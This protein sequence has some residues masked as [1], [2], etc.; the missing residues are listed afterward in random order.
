[1]KKQSIGILVAVVLLALVA[2]FTVLGTAQIHTSEILYDGTTIRW[3]KV[4][5]AKH[6][7][8]SINGSAPIECEEASYTYPNGGDF[9]VTI[10]VHKAI[11]PDQTEQKNF[12]Y[13]QT[14]E[15][16]QFADGVLYWNP[17]KDAD[18]YTVEINGITVATVTE[19]R[20]AYAGA[21]DAIFR[22][23]P[24]SNNQAYYALWSTPY[25]AYILPTPQNV[26]YDRASHTI[27][28]DA[29]PFASSY[30][31]WVDN[32]P[33]VTNTNSFFYS[34][35]NASFTVQV[36]AN[37]DRTQQRFD[38]LRS[39]AKTYTYLPSVANLRVQD[40]IVVWDHVVGATGYRVTVNNVEQPQTTANFFADLA[41]NTPYTIAVL[42]INAD[43]NGYSDW[44]T[45]TFTVLPTPTL[46]AP[47]LE[48]GKVAVTWSRVENA[49][50][51]TLRVLR[52]GV[53][54]NEVSLGADGGACKFEDAYAQ[55]GTY[56]LYLCASQNG[57]ASASGWS[58]A[59]TVIRLAAPQNVQIASDGNVTFAPS[60]NAT[61]YTVKV[62]GATAHTALM[63]PT[64]SLSDGNVTQNGDLNLEIWANGAQATAQSILLPSSNAAT[65]IAHKAGNVSG[66]TVSADGVT[67][68][69]TAGA[70]RYWVFISRN[71]GEPQ[72]YEVTENALPCTWDAVGTYRV[73]VYALMDGENTVPSNAAQTRDVVRL[74]APSVRREGD[75]LLWDHVEGA[76]GY[77][78]LI[79]GAPKTSVAQTYVSLAPYATAQ[80]KRVSVLAV[81]ESTNALVLGSSASQ[82][83]SFA[84]LGTPSA[85]NV[86]N[87]TITWAAVAGATGYQLYIDNL[88]LGQIITDTSY[89]HSGKML[90]AGWHT[91]SVLAISTDEVYLPARATAAVQVYRLA[92]PSLFGDTGTA[93]LRWDLPT[94]L[95]SGV[96]WDK[97]QLWLDGASQEIGERA[98]HFTLQEVAVGT[99]T[100]QVQFVG[101]GDASLTK[102][103][104]ISS[105]IGIFR[106]EARKIAQP[107]VMISRN[108]STVTLN[109]IPNGTDNTYLKC[110]FA[111]GTQTYRGDLRGF[112]HTFSGVEA[113]APCSVQIV[114][115]FFQG[116]V[117]Y[118]DSDWS[119][120]VNG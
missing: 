76:T 22:V 86:N 17:V 45:V 27:S 115:G 1:M 74:T 83:I 23:K 37:G 92:T 56:T 19:T 12:R 118:C 88:P 94:G 61:S 2:I 59:I 89:N 69:A 52:D 21:Q 32:R 18:S 80:I 40:G 39:E 95:P 16:L 111:C 93:N 77:D 34:S 53:L 90:N 7:S 20:F 57:G 36:Q 114:G 97:V 50:G 66:A 70:S 75:T 81:N 30:T 91:V 8:I 46:S 107:S 9:D 79:D 51:Y 104:T 41:P 82:E 38:S 29:V 84:L 3:N 49:N 4:P 110:N 102:T 108:G 28:W 54:L 47:V 113:N 24:N 87:E 55:A 68:N 43:P 6:Y 63:T 71:N 109:A 10:T 85:V 120:Q 103:G 105:A 98:D 48:G 96:T 72:R 64:F 58:N 44:Q 60:A 67:W 100:V 62:N 99:R 73:T 42:P 11:F 117:Y 25:S 14:V 65:A 15:G 78:I 35:N 31:V 119:A 13:L 112:D 5:F 106:F 101:S 116:G 26:T 33:Y